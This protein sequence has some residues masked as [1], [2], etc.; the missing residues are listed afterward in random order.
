MENR[1]RRRSAPTRLNLQ[2]LLD[3]T[4]CYEIVPLSSV[5]ARR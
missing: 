1:C 4:R 5:E 2:N 3:D